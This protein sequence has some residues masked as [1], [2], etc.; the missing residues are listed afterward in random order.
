MERTKLR[1]KTPPGSF[2]QSSFSSAC[3][4]REPMGVAWVISSSVTSRNSGSRFRRSPKFPLAMP[5]SVALSLSVT[6]A[7]TNLMRGKNRGGAA[8]HRIRPAVHPGV[9]R[10]Q[11][12]RHPTCEKGF[13]GYTLGM[14]LIL[15]LVAGLI[16]GLRAYFLLAAAA[17]AIPCICLFIMFLVGFTRPS[18]AKAAHP[19]QP[20]NR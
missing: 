13:F 8:N 19:E 7:G 10:A 20:R 11:T 3:R 1:L 14:G 5:L 18:R 12:A 9:H 15:K 16:E 2:C 17:V 4:K 6:R